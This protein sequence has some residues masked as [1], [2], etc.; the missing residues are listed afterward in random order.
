MRGGG[1][2]GPGAPPRSR[3]DFHVNP[4]NQQRNDYQEQRRYDG[5]GRENQYGNE[6]PYYGS[7]DGP[8]RMRGGMRDDRYGDAGY[9]SRFD[10]SY[11][12]GRD[13]GRNY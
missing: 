5:Y 8:A 1:R 3:D 6:P 13:Q 12:G 11:Y 10:D 9:S 2:G 4:R 7:R